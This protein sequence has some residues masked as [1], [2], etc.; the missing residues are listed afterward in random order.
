MARKEFAQFE[1]VSAAVRGEAGYSAAIAVKALGGFDA[2]RFHKILQDQT[3]KT[4]LAA[5]QAA[6]QA[7]AGLIDVDA[8]GELSW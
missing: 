8:K 2:P 7:L 4:A 1:A 6:E 5:D 3:F